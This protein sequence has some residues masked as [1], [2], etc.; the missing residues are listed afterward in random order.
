MKLYGVRFRRK[1]LCDEMSGRRRR[2]CRS[3]DG[4]VRERDEDIL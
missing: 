3:N 2:M 4:A 1:R